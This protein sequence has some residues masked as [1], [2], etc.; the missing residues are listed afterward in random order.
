MF[1]RNDA[2]ERAPTLHRAMDEVDILERSGGLE[3]ISPQIIKYLHGAIPVGLD[4][5]RNVILPSSYHPEN[6]PPIL[7]LDHHDIGRDYTL[8][9]ATPHQLAVA[10][11]IATQSGATTT[12]NPEWFKGTINNSHFDASTHRK[13]ISITKPGEEK[14]TVPVPL[15]VVT[16]GSDPHN[17]IHEADHWDFFLNEA[18]KIQADPRTRLSTHGL[19]VAAEKR[20][21]ETTHRIEK[22]R[23]R[24]ASDAEIS[25][26]A[27]RFTH[28]SPADAQQ[29]V[30]YIQQHER[31]KHYT[32]RRQDRII[33]PM[34][35]LAIEQLFGHPSTLATDAEIEAHKAIHTLH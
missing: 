32:E 23:E 25:D 16:E 6:G 33:I 3:G 18:G 8:K 28:L 14:Y 13:D 35:I 26:I 12:M 20:A 30:D 11:K 4:K 17:L 1:R 27:Q 10:E 15:L 2:K 19:A 29:I 9:K 34:A 22:N 21:Y 24:G 31:A 5:N 7:A